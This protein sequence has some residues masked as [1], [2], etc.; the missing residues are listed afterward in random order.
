MGTAERV[1]DEAEKLRAFDVIVDHVV[2]GRSQQA[3]PSDAS[4][5]RKTL[6]LRLAISEG[7]AKIRDAGVG[8]D[9][10][11]QHLP[12]WAG[13]V[14]LTLV[15]GEPLQDPPQQSSADETLQALEAPAV[16]PR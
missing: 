3:R 6:V 16:L 5:S 14:P 11:D 13:V 8:D 15:P 10:A 7:S 1:D 9:E 12:V 2:P 4:E